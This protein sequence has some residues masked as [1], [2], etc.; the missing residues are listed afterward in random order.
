MLVESAVHSLGTL[1]VDVPPSQGS[2]AKCYPT[3]LPAW[4]LAAAMHH[5]QRP[6]D[7]RARSAG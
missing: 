7:Q 3:A 4:L 6:C 1:A 2:L 5:W